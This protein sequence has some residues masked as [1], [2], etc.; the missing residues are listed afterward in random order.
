MACLDLLLGRDN[1]VRPSS[2]S[3]ADKTELSGLC[4]ESSRNRFLSSPKLDPQ[5]RLEPLPWLGPPS[6]RETTARRN[7][8]GHIY[9]SDP[10]PE[11]VHRFLLFRDKSLGFSTLV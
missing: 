4:H 3:R 1:A 10:A 9:S 8:V 2:F 5:L 7:L 6:Y 11:E